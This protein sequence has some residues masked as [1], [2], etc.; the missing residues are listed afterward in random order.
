MEEPQTRVVHAFIEAGC[1]VRS[2][3]VFFC[4]DEPLG[5]ALLL[6]AAME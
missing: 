3:D 6:L 1:S 2:V 4:K 5:E